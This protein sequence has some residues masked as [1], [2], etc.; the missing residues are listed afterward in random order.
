MIIKAIK[1]MTEITQEDLLR[2]AYGETSSQKTALIKEALERDFEL[3]ASF[4]NIRA[5]QRRLDEEVS[6]PSIDVI[7]RIM[8]YASRKQKKVEIH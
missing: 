4:E 5:M 3:R 6:A 8:D 2:Y 1:V 7:E